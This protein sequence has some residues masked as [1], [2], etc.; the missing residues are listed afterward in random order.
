[1]SEEEFSVVWRG[2]MVA[3]VIGLIAHWAMLKLMRERHPA[4]WSELGS[5]SLFMNNSVQNGMAVLRYLWRRTYLGTQD[6]AFI[7]ICTFNR[8]YGLLYLA[9]FVVL[10]FL[11]P[12]W[13]W[14]KG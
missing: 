2:L 4:I 5:P 9:V 1:M 8:W 7:R 12:L 11:V 13:P 14:L 3:V 10:L 6:E